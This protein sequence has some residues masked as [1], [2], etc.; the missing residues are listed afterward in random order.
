M[1]ERKISL[2]ELATLNDGTCID[3][4]IVKGNNNSP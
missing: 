2:D 4:D 3:M 1:A